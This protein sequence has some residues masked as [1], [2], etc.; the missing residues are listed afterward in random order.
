[1]LESLREV[2]YKQK[3]GKISLMDLNSIQQTDAS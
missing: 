1:M 2:I 3:Q